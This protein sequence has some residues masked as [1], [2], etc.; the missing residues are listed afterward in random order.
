MKHYHEQVQTI[1][2]CF[3]IKIRLLFFVSRFLILKKRKKFDFFFWLSYRAFIIVLAFWGIIPR[4]WQLPSIDRLSMHILLIVG[5]R[6]FFIHSVLLRLKKKK[7]YFLISIIHVLCIFLVITHSLLTFIVLME[8]INAILFLYIAFFGHQPERLY[9]LAFFLLLALMIALPS[10]YFLFNEEVV[11]KLN[12]YEKKILLF[13]FLFKLPIIWLHA[14]LPKA[15]LESPLVV[16][17]LLRGIF[18]KI[19]ILGVFRIYQWLGDIKGVF[20][21]VPLAITNV[22]LA[23]IFVQVQNDLKRIVALSSVVHINP[24]LFLI[25]SIRE[26]FLVKISLLMAIRHTLIS[27]ILFT[28]ASICSKERGSRRLFVTNSIISSNSYFASLYSIII[29]ANLALPLRI[30]FF[31][32]ISLF[33]A[34]LWIFPA[35]IFLIFMSRLL[36]YLY[37][38]A[39]LLAIN[40]V[41]KKRINIKNNFVIESLFITRLLLVFTWN[42]IFGF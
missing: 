25:P 4:W 34:V 40:Y 38:I 20:F 42:P 15:H 24:F 11:I 9:T 7:K 31:R 27:N 18:L 36:A 35:S 23:P 13:V 17:L 14:W 22:V 21:L 8:I 12:R 19:G 1:L 41:S 33:S 37:I 29:L 3:S 39:P 28:V 10:I 16:S 26:E 2:I 6:L 5:V 30:T 32:E